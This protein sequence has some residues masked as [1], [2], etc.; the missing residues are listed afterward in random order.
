MQVILSNWSVNVQSIKCLFCSTLVPTM[1]QKDNSTTKWMDGIK[2][3]VKIEMTN[4][5]VAYIL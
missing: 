4:K 3:G 1:L 2:Q 5:Q